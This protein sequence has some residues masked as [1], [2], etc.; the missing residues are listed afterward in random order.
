SWSRFV[1][2]HPPSSVFIRNAMWVSLLTYASI[3]QNE[4]QFFG[5]LDCFSSFTSNLPCMPLYPI[6]FAVTSVECLLLSLIL[7]RNFISPS[8]SSAYPLPGWFIFQVPSG[9]M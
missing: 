6:S 1:I 8:S 3:A 2:F 5:F 7:G 4:S 9:E